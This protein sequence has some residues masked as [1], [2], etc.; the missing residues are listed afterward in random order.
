MLG[1]GE[2]IKKTWEV[3]S[4]N[5]KGLV[6]VSLVPT[7]VSLAVGVVFAIFGA[8]GMGIGAM[9][10]LGVPVAAV[11]VVLGILV[12]VGVIYVGA[13][14]AVAMVAAAKE[15]IDGQVV[16]VK[17]TYGKAKPLVWKYVWV[18]FLVS[19][20]VS[21]GWL[22][23]LVPGIV[24]GIWFFA[25]QFVVVDEGLGG[26]AAMMKSKAYVK[27]HAAGVFG[28]MFVFG[29]LM[30][31]V[32]IV[33]SLVSLVPVL[34]WVVS[35]VA[36]V[37]LVPATVVFMYLLYLE[38][39]KLAPETVVPEKGGVYVAIGC[40]GLLVPILLIIATVVL[41]AINPAAQIK[42]ASQYRNVQL[43]K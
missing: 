14:G 36:N 9:G 22:L 43:M 26:M 15:A 23:L 33:V 40:L 19:M 13:W 21:G 32:Y 1:A 4:K 18:M 37:G 41:V 34:G 5:W 3:F 38:V 27:G 28:R 6:L 10:G 35:T 29:L 16:K 12:L 25:A 7:L 11:M 17:E 42:K 24:F 31:G 39:K 2:L 8:V 20:V 30:M